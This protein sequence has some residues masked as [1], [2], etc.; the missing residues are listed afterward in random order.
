MR[1]IQTTRTR[2]RTFHHHLEALIYF[3]YSMRNL[4]SHIR[5]WSLLSL[6][7]IL[8]AVAAILIQGR[9]ITVSSMSENEYAYLRDRFVATVDQED[10]RAALNQLRSQSAND[11]RVLKSCHALVHEIG[12]A[13]YEKFDDVAMAL[14]YQDEICG[15]GYTHGVIESYIAKVGYSVERLK[16]LCENYTGKDRANCYHGVGHGLMDYSGNNIPASLQ[17]CDQMPLPEDRIR[18]DEGL[19]MEYFDGDKNVHPTKQDEELFA[20]CKEDNKPYQKGACYFYAPLKYLNEHPGAYDD[21]FATC[22]DAEEGYVATCI[23]GAASRI[24]KENIKNISFVSW[25]CTKQAKHQRA[26]AEGIGSYYYTHYGDP[27]KVRG[28]CEALP[29]D[30]PAAC[31][32]SIDTAAPGAHT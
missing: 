2:A 3:M 18:C 21:M 15:A 7:L 1:M 13:A 11:Q 19:Y 5:I 10:P 25:M 23:K 12:H 30:Y 20:A 29:K 16:S 17:A 32:R 26:C 9:H 14:A 4:L 27:E 8:A 22:R 6:L 31:M 24:T 28:M